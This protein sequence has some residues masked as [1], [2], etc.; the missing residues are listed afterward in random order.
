M[1]QPPARYPNPDV[2]YVTRPWEVAE[3]AELLELHNTGLRGSALVQAL[4]DK[5][6]S[7]RNANAVNVKATRLLREGLTAPSLAH[8]PKSPSSR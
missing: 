5:G 2:Y 8:T 6:W 3:K 1:S 7:Q 4:V